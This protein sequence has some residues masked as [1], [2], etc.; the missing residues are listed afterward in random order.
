MKS[1]D[2]GLKQRLIGAIILLALAVIFLPVLF[3]REGLE[4]VDTVS[5]IPPQPEIVPI[6]IPE[7]KPPANVEPAP[8]PEQMFVP[9]ESSPVEPEPELPGLQTDGTPKS[10][11]L[12]IASF[13]SES[14]ANALRDKLMGAGYS[15]YTRTIK[16]KNGTVTRVFVGPK[17]EKERLMAEQ[18]AIDKRFQ[19]ESILLEF[20]TGS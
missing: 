14:N 16:Y 13:R 17:L 3:D 15:A 12:Q 18:Q 1:M 5:Q 20:Q 9:D 8:E 2:D 7:P 11:V 4:P 10:W 19:V 6:T